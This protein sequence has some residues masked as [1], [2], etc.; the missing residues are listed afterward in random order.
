MFEKQIKLKSYVGGRRVFL[1]ITD[2]DTMINCE[3]AIELKD[4][5]ELSKKRIKKIDERRFL[6]FLD[7]KA[8]P[9]EKGTKFIAFNIISVVKKRFDE[10][11]AAKQIESLA[12]YVD[13][14]LGGYYD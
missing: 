12:R 9:I 13:E 10:G 3:G 14:V 4:S 1:I 5:D 7:E 6:F 2:Y 11:R 8:N